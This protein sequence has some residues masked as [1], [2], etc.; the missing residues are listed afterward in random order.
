MGRRQLRARDPAAEPGALDRMTRAGRRR[1]DVRGD[2]GG[3]NVEPSWAWPGRDPVH[4]RYSRCDYSARVR[5]A[6]L[7]RRHQTAKPTGAAIAARTSE[8]GS[9]TPRIKRELIAKSPETAGGSSI[10]KTI[11]VISAFVSETPMKI[12][13]PSSSAV[14]SPFSVNVPRLFVP[15]KA[16]M[17]AVKG[18]ALSS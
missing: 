1:C 12:A 11:E 6:C 16:V 5:A 9:G 18:P 14:E 10:P 4:G 17:V 2:R 15:E 3:S 8:E 7:R 13:E